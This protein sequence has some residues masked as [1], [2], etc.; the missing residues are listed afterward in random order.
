MYPHIAQYVSFI[1]L[2]IQFYEGK[3]KDSRPSHV[4]LG[5]SGRWVEHRTEAGV[6]ATLRVS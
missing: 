2:H 3:V 5:T 1:D 6:T 4:K